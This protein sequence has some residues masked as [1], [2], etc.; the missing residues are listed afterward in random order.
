VAVDLLSHLPAK[1]WWANDPA[2][3]DKALAPEIVGWLARA[4]LVV[5][6][7]GYFA[8]WLFDALTEAQTFFVTRMREKASYSVEQV[9]V[10]KPQVRDQIIQLGIYK[11]NRQCQHP[12]RLVEVFVNARWQRYLTNVL[13]PQRLTIVEVVAL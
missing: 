10:N 13:D 6:D 3:N 2:S 12:L 7:L 11:G 1:L 8:F 4:S 9:L 5:F